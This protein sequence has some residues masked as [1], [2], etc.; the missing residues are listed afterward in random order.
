[1]AQEGQPQRRYSKSAVIGLLFVLGAPLLAVMLS[2]L[3]PAYLVDH[4]WGD[5]IGIV[6]L[7]VM[8]VGTYLSFRGVHAVRRSKHLRGMWVAVLGLILGPGLVILAYV[9]Y[10]IRLTAIRQEALP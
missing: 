5:L 9:V 2:S 7:V 6:T 4:G 10:V 3:L 8:A 1:M